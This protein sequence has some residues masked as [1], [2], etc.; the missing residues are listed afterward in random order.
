MAE[1]IQPTKTGTVDFVVGDRTFQTWYKILGD[2]KT[3]DKR[4]IVMLHGGP[5][6]NHVYMTPHERLFTDADIPV[7]FYNQIGLRQYPDSPAE[8]WTVDL[9]KDELDNLL[10]YLGIRDNFDLLGHS[11]GGIFG[12]DYASN[13]MHP[14]LKRLILTNTFCS[15][16][17]YLQG[18]EYWRDH[19]PDG[20]GEV[21]KKHQAEGTTDSQEYKDA[22]VVYRNTHLCTL[23]PLPEKLLQSIGNAEGNR[24]PEFAMNKRLK[25]WSVIDVLHNVA[26]PTLLISAPEDDMWEPA[27]RPFFLNI[28]KCKWVELQNSTHVPMYEEPDNYFKILID[29]LSNVDA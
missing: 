29:F 22:L 11:W 12:S 25:D 6:F 17:L 26:C 24:H 8:F 28:P 23:A 2:L 1:I 15:S 18:G 19:L 13:R 14:G 16:K 4:P 3:S 7:V 20:L 5:G 9:F 10:E 21:I 27:V